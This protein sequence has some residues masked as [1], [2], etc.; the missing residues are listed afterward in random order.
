MNREYEY[1]KDKVI[2][3]DDDHNVTG[4]LP[5]TENV[6][7]RLVLEN[8]IEFLEGKVSFFKDVLKDVRHSRASNKKLF[9]KLFA[10]CVI[11]CYVVA[12]TV[13][14]ILGDPSATVTTIFGNMNYVV[15][16]LACIVTPAYLGLM[17]IVYCVLD[18]SPSKDREVKLKNMFLSGLDELERLKTKKVELEFSDSKKVDV[19]NVSKKIVLIDDRKALDQVQKIVSL[20]CFYAKNPDKVERLYN[21][22]KLNSF[23]QEQ[24]IIDCSVLGVFE[25]Y[26][27]NKIYSKIPQ[28][29]DVMTLGL[30]KDNN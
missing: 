20:K 23:L 15:A 22:G 29:E 7:E 4:F 14:S 17:G 11:P 21:E 24:G 6:E 19:D 2:V 9:S 26:V 3:R 12:A 27:A 8:Q 16:N 30:R 28:K 18:A 10:G 5:A 1:V 13:T 25:D